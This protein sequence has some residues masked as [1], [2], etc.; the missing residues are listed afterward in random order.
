MDDELDSLRAE[1]VAKR[2]RQLAA[3][4]GQMSVRHDRDPHGRIV[5]QFG[6]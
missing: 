4:T 3:E 1:A 6:R 2:P 5:R